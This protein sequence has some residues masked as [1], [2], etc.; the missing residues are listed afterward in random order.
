MFSKKLIDVLSVKPF[1]SINNL[2]NYGFA[3]MSTYKDL[4]CFISIEY[5]LLTKRIV[6]ENIFIYFSRL[7]LFCI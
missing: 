5:R 4:D 2:C 3:T 1:L 7:R 6:K